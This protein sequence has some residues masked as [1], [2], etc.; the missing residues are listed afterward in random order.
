MPMIRLASCLGMAEKGR[1]LSA[2]M[3]AARAVEEIYSAK[4]SLES[5]WPPLQSRIAD[6]RE[7]AFAREIVSGTLRWFVRL[8]F[9][10]TQISDRKIADARLRAIVLTG[11]YQLA[12]MRVADHAAISEAVKTAKKLGRSRASGFV[13]AVLRRYQRESA[14][15]QERA[16]QSLVTRHAYPEWFCDQVKS[17]WLD[18]AEALLAAGNERAPM[19][20][21]IN[22]RRVDAAEWRMRA[23]RQTGVSFHKSPV[24]EWALH[25]DEPIPVTQLPGFDDGLVSVQDA[26][27]QMAAA[28]VAPQ[29]GN[30]V[31]DACAAPGGKT[32]H[33]L[34][35]ADIALTAVDNDATRLGRVS[36][37]LDRLRLQARLV[38][39]DASV[40]SDWWDGERFDR[41]LLDVPCSASGVV[42]RHP[43][44]KLLRRH[45]D[46][47]PLAQRQRAILEACWPLLAPGGR[48][49]YATCSVF[50][51]ENAEIIAGFLRDHPQAR[52]NMPS[53]DWGRDCN[54]GRQI[55]TGEARMDGFYYSC[56]EHA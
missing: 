19:W 4:G 35:S 33:L 28:L 5:V 7:Q 55:M 8:D 54:P 13:N 52:L 15:L 44:I 49:V 18:D 38:H 47:E 9:I 39:G 48:L 17:D 50:E 21:R 41:I 51:L 42:R 26:G 37:N 27:A 14:V 12:L 40:P 43:D 45:S 1:A 23:E 32:G 6:P 2:R 56:L 24:A 31:L 29:D 25:P 10:L 46:L 16:D 20:L 36:D 22:R 3:A 11:L 34:E 30:R 53:A